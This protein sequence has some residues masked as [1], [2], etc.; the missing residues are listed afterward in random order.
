MHPEFCYTV[1]GLCKSKYKVEFML[2]DG[3]HNP[4]GGEGGCLYFIVIVV[5][6][7]TFRFT[8]HL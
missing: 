2:N 4:G 5:K 3:L 7:T 1:R 8:M 6:V